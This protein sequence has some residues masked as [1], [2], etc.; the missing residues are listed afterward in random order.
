M[1]TTDSSPTTL[2]RLAGAVDKARSMLF[3]AAIYA[4]DTTHA[5]VVSVAIAV[6]SAHAAVRDHIAKDVFGRC[7]IAV[8][9]Y[10]PRVDEMHLDN[11]QLSR[12]TP[13]YRHSDNLL[14]LVILYI[15]KRFF[16]AGTGILDT[17]SCH[18]ALLLAHNTVAEIAYSD[19][20]AVLMRGGG[21]G[22]DGSGGDGADSA[23]SAE[24][25]E[26]AVP[27]AE[28]ADVVQNEED[29]M[30]IGDDIPIPV[31]VPTDDEAEFDEEA[32]AKAETET[33]TDPLPANAPVDEETFLKLLFA[34]AEFYTLDEKTGS[35][36]ILME[37]KD[38]TE[39]VKARFDSFLP[40]SHFKFTAAEVANMAT[41]DGQV[42][43][44]AVSV[45]DL[46]IQY[47]GWTIKPRLRFVVETRTSVEELVFEDCQVIDFRPSMHTE[48]S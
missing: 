4:L 6:Q 11:A 14:W 47:E 30:E 5:A 34:T 13:V 40:D 37:T 19:G 42:K 43:N 7:A 44:G 24:S 12:R 28:P 17:A 1:A 3:L 41:M 38:I 25:L 18:V 31:P 21:S 32:A 46:V 10:A 26:S 36:G 16:R 33:E 35:V 9:V 8:T 27:D 22:S 2:A 48:A 39:F 15:S 23:E 20:T 29:F 45:G